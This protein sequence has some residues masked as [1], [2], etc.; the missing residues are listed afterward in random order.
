MTIII[1]TNHQ[2]TKHQGTK[3]DIWH[4]LDRFTFDE[5]RKITTDTLELIE[6][7][8]ESLQKDLE[9]KTNGL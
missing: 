1:H 3:L 2:T 8:K 4:T 5:A 7:L 9:F 6:K